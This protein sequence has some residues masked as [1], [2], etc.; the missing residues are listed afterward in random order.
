MVNPLIQQHAET[1]RGA[2][3]PGV[4]VEL[5]DTSGKCMNVGVSSGEITKNILLPTLNQDAVMIGRE[6]GQQIVRKRQLSPQL[7]GSNIC[8]CAQRSPRASSST[9]IENVLYRRGARVRDVECS[10]EPRVREVRRVRP[11][12]LISF[13]TFAT[14]R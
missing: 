1:Q 13:C 2:F 4:R 7:N 14:I 12:V 10:D 11:R 9:R 3:H 5:R 6:R 8:S